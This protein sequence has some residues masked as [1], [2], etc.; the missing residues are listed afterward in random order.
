M[1][2]VAILTGGLATRLRPI[3]DDTPKALI[4][5]A[6]RPFIL[7]QIDYLKNQG[8]SRVVL[9]V[10]H[11]GEQV[12]CFVGDGSAHGLEVLYSWDGSKP[13]GTGGA[14]RQA[15]PLLG[16]QFFVLYGDSYLPIDFRIVES[17]F[18]V[19]GKPAMMTVLRNANR[20]DKSNVE[21]VDGIVIEYNKRAP[22]QEMEHID[23]GL[24]V[25]SACVLENMP[26]TETFDLADIYHELSL[27]GHLAGHEVFER[28]FEIGSHQGLDET[29]RY[30]SEEKTA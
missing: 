18:L 1:L 8:I 10:G 16:D 30:F 7:R 14:I 12:E 21:F 5:V 26:T 23:Y 27:L 17:N 3:S 22:R 29:I 11:L 6:G 4:D 2:P 25:L 24:G 28:F 19:C 20:W 15:L 9:C 13:L